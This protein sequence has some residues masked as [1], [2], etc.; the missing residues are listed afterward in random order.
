M[1]LPDLLSVEQLAGYLG[2][3]PAAVRALAHR[4]SLAYIRCGRAIR[5]REDDVARFLDENRRPAAS[6]TSRDGTRFGTGRPRGRGSP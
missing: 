5:F 2:K 3:K 6:E 1:S 4:G